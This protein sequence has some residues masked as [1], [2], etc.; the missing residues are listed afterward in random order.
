VVK[1]PKLHKVTAMLALAPNDVADVS[2]NSMIGLMAKV[3]AQLN[4]LN[5]CDINRAFYADRNLS[6]EVG[7][8]VI[9]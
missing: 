5:L 1:T 3:A 7:R 9:R 6:H 8:I 4:K 2:K